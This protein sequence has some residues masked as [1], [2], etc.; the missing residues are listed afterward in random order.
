[1]NKYIVITD[2]DRFIVKA[3][4]FYSAINAAW[5]NMSSF[6]EIISITKINLALVED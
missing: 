4:N 2:C 1:M 6:E 3:D 5:K